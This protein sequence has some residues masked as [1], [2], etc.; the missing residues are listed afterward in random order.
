MVFVIN[1]KKLIMK[2]FLTFFVLLFSSTV[3]AEDISDFQIEGISIGDSLLDYI[4][5]EN[6]IDQ[7]FNYENDIDKIFQVAEFYKPDFLDQYESIQF[8]IKTNDP[9]YII[10]GIR[11]G[12]FFNNI[13]NCYKKMNDVAADVSL[14]FKKSN[15][16]NQEDK[17]HPLDK[18]GKSTTRGIAFFLET[19]NSSVRCYDW[20]ENMPYED[21]MSVSIKT[22]EYNEWLN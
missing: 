6:I 20:S 5:E 11:A 9:K 22:S 15:R 12:I 19:G 7:L 1:C 8:A 14:V 13:N 18:S 16:I 4:N 10:H 21:N 2:V 17:S 3:G